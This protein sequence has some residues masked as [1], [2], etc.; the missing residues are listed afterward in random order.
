MSHMFIFLQ[1]IELLHLSESMGDDEREEL[2]QVI[3]IMDFDMLVTLYDIL[4]REARA[5][6]EIQ[7][8]NYLYDR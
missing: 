2:L 5:L 7:M 6:M 1:V 3:T 8:E 4:E